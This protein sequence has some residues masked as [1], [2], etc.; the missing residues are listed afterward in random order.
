MRKGFTL[1]EL[2]IIVMIIGILWSIALPKMQAAR[3]LRKNQYHYLDKV[4]IQ[5][6]FYK[7]QWGKIIK[8]NKFDY[9]IKLDDSGMEVNIN[10]LDLKGE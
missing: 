8:D 3:E 5:R 2:I 6:G 10:I 4:Q 9:T 7:G 1:M